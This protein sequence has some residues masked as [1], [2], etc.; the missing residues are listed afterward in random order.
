VT[1]C[2]GSP[3]LFSGGQSEQ[4]F[5]RV[6]QFSGLQ[7]STNAPYPVT[8][9]VQDRQWTHF[10]SKYYTVYADGF[11]QFEHTYMNP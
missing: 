10:D 6:L 5:L 9:H 8:C 1:E 3:I 7:H 4:I 11:I 2:K